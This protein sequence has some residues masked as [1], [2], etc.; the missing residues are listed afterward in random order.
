ML[1]EDDASSRLAGDAAA[2]P[3]DSLDTPAERGRRPTLVVE[4]QGPIRQA[5]SLPNKRPTNLSATEHL[6]PFVSATTKPDGTAM[7]V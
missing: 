4:R 5:S 3:K 2:V 6:E 1:N 7:L